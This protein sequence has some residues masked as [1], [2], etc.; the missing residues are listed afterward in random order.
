M[1]GT[2]DTVD[3]AHHRPTL[4][5]RRRHQRTFVAA[6]AYNIAW[7]LF[8]VMDPQWLFR[9]AGMPHD[10]HPQIFATLGMVIGLYGILYLEVARVPESGWLMAAVGFTGK[11]LGP[12]GLA[13]L[14]IS[15]Q[16]PLA[17][18]VIC[19]SNDVIW[20]IPFALY[21][22]DAWPSFR[23]S[24]SVDGQR[25]RRPVDQ[26]STQTAGATTASDRT[27]EYAA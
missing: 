10:N 1:I 27:K 21:L 19:L 25:C 5:R 3:A 26:V 14:L 24:L 4:P 22:K 2:F 15:G 12:V 11:L 20:W 9:V 6:G 13:L 16:W 17:S 7:G 18:S 23:H 8:S